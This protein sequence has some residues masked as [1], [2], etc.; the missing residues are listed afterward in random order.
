M[1]GGQLCGHARASQPDTW[2]VRTG[3][4]SYWEAEIAGWWIRF[5]QDR[6]LGN[7]GM[8]WTVAPQEAAQD[9]SAGARPARGFTEGPGLGPFPTPAGAWG[10]TEESGKR[11]HQRPGRR[12][13]PILPPPSVCAPTAVEIYTLVEWVCFFFSKTFV[14]FL[15]P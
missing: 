2:V 13:P 15:V 12:V 7:S 3:Y 9:S 14:L 11:R 6:T 4:C 5:L 10:A 8:T 1:P